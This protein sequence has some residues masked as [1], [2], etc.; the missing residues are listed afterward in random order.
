[1]L[2]Q[3]T[4]WATSRYGVHIADASA[5]HLRGNTI[6]GNRAGVVI[7]GP[8]A[9]QNLLF[10]NQIGTDASGTAEI[11]NASYGVWLAEGA[12]D[13]DIGFA[14]VGGGNII[15]S[16]GVH[17]VAVNGADTINN[18][19]LRNSI[20]DNVFAGIDLGTDGFTPNDSG[21]ADTGPNLL[22]NYPEFISVGRC[23]PAG[24]ESAITLIHCRQLKLPDSGRV[25]PCRYL[26]AR[27]QGLSRI[28]LVYRGE[29]ERRYQD[30]RVRSRF[31]ALGRSENRGDCH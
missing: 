31:L 29:L 7:R 28:R 11:G 22:Q 5:K 8:N 2:P 20:Y 14:G 23:W 10:G 30:D 6:S 19:I 12:H 1:M 26:L 24:F 27:R 21:D 3:A 4:R 9:E 16:N 25:F 17:G 18:Q 13:N 15:S